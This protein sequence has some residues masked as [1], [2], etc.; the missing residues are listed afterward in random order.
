MNEIAQIGE[1]R[2]YSRDVTPESNSFFR[3]AMSEE[4]ESAS[5]PFKQIIC[6]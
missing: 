1:A 3:T 2:D 4:S 6:H 5:A